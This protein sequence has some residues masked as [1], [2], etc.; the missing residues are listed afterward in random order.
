MVQ[1]EK[2]KGDIPMSYYFLPPHLHLNNIGTR[3][4]LLGSV[5]AATQTSERE[6]EFF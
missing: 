5:A 3:Q 6:Y 2:N 4:I 1:E